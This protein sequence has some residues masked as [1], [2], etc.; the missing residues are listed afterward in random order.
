MDPFNYMDITKT[1]CPL[2]MFGIPGAVAIKANEQDV[3]C[4]L[5]PFSGS[6]SWPTIQGFIDGSCFTVDIKPRD[7]SCRLLSLTIVTIFQ[8]R[9]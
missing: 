8:L 7:F 9:V 3:F 2:F 5:P 1:R 6:C 4:F